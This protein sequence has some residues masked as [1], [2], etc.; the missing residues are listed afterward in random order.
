MRGSCELAQE[1]DGFDLIEFVSSMSQSVDA[2]TLTDGFVSRWVTHE[3]FDESIEISLRDLSRALFDSGEVH[4]QL[5]FPDG[6]DLFYSVNVLRT[7]IVA[8]R[9]GFD[10]LDAG[11]RDLVI[12]FGIGRFEGLCHDGG[13]VLLVVDYDDAYEDF[14][15]RL[16]L[17]SGAQLPAP[18]PRVVGYNPSRVVV[19]PDALIGRQNTFIGSGIVSRAADH[20]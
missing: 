19:S 11:Q 1:V 14:D 7:K 6:S 5:W 13:A 4:F 8:Q 16:S 2:R 9:L 18:L 12:N 10:G 15:L 17:E 3:D 20:G